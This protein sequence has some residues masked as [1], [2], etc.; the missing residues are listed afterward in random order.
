[1]LKG[2]RYL[3]GWLATGV[4]AMAVVLWAFPR[5]YPLFP[6]DWQISKADARMI[7]LERL[8]DLGELPDSPYV[9]TRIDEA[10]ALEHRLQSELKAV[11]SRV[12]AESHLGES[13][14]TWETTVW[15]PGARSQEWSHH[16]RVTPSGIVTELLIR[17][18]PDQSIEPIDPGEAIQQANEF[19]TEQGFRLEEFDEPEIRTR[20]LQSRTDLFLRY[21][22]LEALLGDRY[23]YGVEVV[24]A[25]NRLAGFSRFFD[26]PELAAIRSSFQ[27]I[28]LLVQAKVFLPLLILPLMAIPFVRRYHAGEI[29]VRRGIQISVVVVACG[30][31]SMIFSAND[32]S[33]GVLLGALSR[34]Q[35]NLVTAL[36]MVILLFFPMGLLSFLSWSVGESL[37][38]E[39][40]G[41]RL[42][43]FDALFQGAW[44]NATFAWASLRGTVSGIAVAALIWTVLVA[45]RSQG[46]WAYGWLVLGPWWESSG[47]FSIPMLSFF[48]A[49]ALYTGLFGQLFLV[50]YWERLLGVWGSVAIA[51]IAAVVLFFGSA[52]VYPFSWNL[53]VWLLP[54]LAFIGLFLRYGIFTAIMAG[55]TS[56]VIM[57]VVP[58]FS[59]SSFSIQLQVALSLLGVAVP[60]IVSAR[61][62]TSDEEF[63]Y[64]YEDIPPHVRRIA[65]RERQ[66]VELKTA[67]GIQASILPDLPVQLNGVRLSHRY[68]PATEVGGDFYDVLALEDGRLS[69]AVGDVAGHGVSSGLVMSMAKSALSVQVT[70]NPEVE[71]VFTTLNRMVFQSARKRLLATL[72]YALVDPHERELQYAS[73]GHLFPYLISSG[74]QV[75]SLESVSYPL[76][77]RECLDVRVRKAKLEAG[78]LL[79]LF[80]DGVVEAHPEFSDDLFGFDRL[81]RTLAELASAG[82]EGVCEGVLKALDRHTRGAPQQD[83]LTI[84]VLQIP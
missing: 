40:K 60:L 36:Q 8:R 18:P 73:A 54:P 4:V 38:R 35:V 1:M 28:Q 43:A 66:R 61:S 5:A 71:A 14:L 24:F 13:L 75:R 52:Y 29:G 58:F 11:D 46:V 44:N 33:A 19:L 7:S 17:I 23:P 3:L 56:S 49:F 77:V 16:A 30:L 72:C 79:F 22:H 57:G 70:F 12:L 55:F 32:A 80:S 68:Q 50:S 47:W 41:R 27:P 37:S 9:V 51:A 31:V 69:V 42:A 84:L 21:R 39:K 25:G 81:E 6:S 45:L 64:R 78:D 83:D 34:R 63:E 59:T 62:L 67:R 20:E 48:L 26:D 82:V 76:G 53:L 10:A 74:G 2:N 15:P 65:E